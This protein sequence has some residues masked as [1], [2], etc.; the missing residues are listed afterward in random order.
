MLDITLLWKKNVLI[1]L[2]LFSFLSLWALPEDGLD[3][4]SKIKIVTTIFPLME[5]SKAVS[6]KQGEVS[7]LLPPGAE[8]HT[9]K[10]RPSDIIRVSSAD[11]FI[12][13]GADLEPWIHSF[14]GSIKNPKLRVLEAGS[15]LSL[16]VEDRSF[17]RHGHQHQAS[18]PHF[19]LDF[20]M[21]QVIVDKI[22]SLLSELDA[23]N[24]F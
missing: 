21:D 15:V 11:L 4:S 13:I 19:W 10:P 16:L 6:G 8:I 1:F 18:D 24:S 7:L 5:F 3:A 23:K 17:L 14:L 20:E 9:W 12:Y 22:A 2:I